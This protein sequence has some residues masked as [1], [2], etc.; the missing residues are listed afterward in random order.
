MLTDYLALIFDAATTNFKRLGGLGP[1]LLIE[2]IL[3]GGTLIALLLYVYR[4]R[5]SVLR[6]A[7]A[8]QGIGHVEVEMSQLS[9][10][11]LGG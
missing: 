5:R 9:S 8:G 1:Y 3:P 7:S 4:H 6:A 10:V 11:H 2:L